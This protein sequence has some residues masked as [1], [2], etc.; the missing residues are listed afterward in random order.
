MTL[1]LCFGFATLP[2]CCARDLQLDHFIHVQARS[3]ASGLP[4]SANLIARQTAG[5]WFGTPDELYRAGRIEHS[6]WR[7]RHGARSSSAIANGGDHGVLVVFRAW[8]PAVTVPPMAPRPA[9][10]RICWNNGWRSVREESVPTAIPWWRLGA[11]GQIALA[12]S[13]I[14]LNA[15]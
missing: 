8:P 7:L 14:I 9:A 3:E 5:P 11:C 13:R 15:M 2:P 12:R 4:G 10:S 1:A 6:R